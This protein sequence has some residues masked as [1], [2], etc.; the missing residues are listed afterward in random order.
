MTFKLNILI[1]TEKNENVH[2]LF[3]FDYWKYVILFLTSTFNTE[4]F[5]NADLSRWLSTKIN[6]LIEKQWVYVYFI[7][8]DESWKHQYSLYRT[9][10]YISAVK[11]LAR[12]DV[13]K[14][15]LWKILR[16]FI[17]KI[18]CNHNLEIFKNEN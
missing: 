7:I 6:L 5:W 17:V 8:R 13:E 14:T 4:T 18:L 16:S 9:L 10:K 2:F 3:Y 15:N 12:L 11:F 1:I